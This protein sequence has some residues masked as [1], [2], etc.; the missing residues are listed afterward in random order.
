MLSMNWALFSGMGDMKLKDE[1]VAHYNELRYKLDDQRRKVLQTLTSQYALLKVTR[2]R[3]AAG[4]QEL[5]S[6][7][8]A[9]R[10]VSKRMLSGNQS[11]LDVLD[12]FD[13]YY[14]VRVRLVNLHV[15]EIGSL[16][17]IGR[18]LQGSPQMAAAWDLLPASA[19]EN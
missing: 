15:A 11:L 18:M 8:S 17:Q 12:V 14:Q 4:Y 13:R 3:I 6:T 16:A 10:S 9:A 2:Q 5:E 1:K 19:K 7:A